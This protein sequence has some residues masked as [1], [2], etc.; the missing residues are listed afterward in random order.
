MPSRR[1]RGCV[2]A[3]AGVAAFVA[4]SCSALWWRLG[5]GPLSIDLVTPWLISALEERLGGGHRI[6]V[7]GTVLERDE[8]GRT[9]LRLRD[10]VLRGADGAVIASAPRAEVGIA[11]AS[12]LSGHLRAERLSLIGAEMALR[13]E[14]D[15]SLNVFAGS[16]DSSPASG[17]IEHVASVRG[18]DTRM[19]TAMAS[20]IKEA[21]ASAVGPGPLATAVGWLRTLDAVGF[22]GQDLIEIGLKNGNIAVDDRRTGKQLSFG[23]INLSLTRLNQGGAA[24]NLSSMGTDGPWSIN[25]TVVPR[26]DGS[27]SIEAVVR[28]VSPKDIQLA[29]RMDG[30]D[31]QADMPLSAVIRAEVGPDGV[32]QT[33]QGRMLAGAGYIGDV[34]D[35]TGRILIDEAQVELRWDAASRSMTVP[36]EIHAGA[37]RVTLTAQVESPRDGNGL[38]SFTIPQGMVQLASLGKPHEPPL[39]LDRVSLRAVFDADKKRFDLEQADLRG[40]SGGV[41]LSG[42]LDF[43]GPDPRIMVG[44][45]G[46][47]M[48]AAAF[49]RLWPVF[50]APH[51]RHWVEE[52]V[53]AG[54]VDRVVV[55]ANMRL[56]SLRPDGRAL[57]E[58]ALSIEIVSKGTTIRPVDGL[59]PVKDVELVTRV[60]GK[61]ASVTFGRGLVDLPSG[62]KL[63]VA[64]GSFE[65][66][67]INARQH[68][69]RA[70]FRIDGGLE[71]AAELLAM[72]P[73]R[74]AAALPFDVGTA[75]GAVAA[76]VAIALPLT[77]EM[78]KGSVVYGVDA[79]V[80]GFTAE[81]FVRGQKTEAA[82]LRVTANQDV[83][84]IKG[85]MKIGGTPGAVDYR[86]ARGENEGELRI[87]A[88]LDDAGRA[89]LGLD[90]GT[91][92]FGP[93][94]VKM[95]GR[96]KLAERDSRFNIEADLTQ[97]R[98][99][100][101]LPGWN[102]P[103][104]RAARASFV[105]L[106]RVQSMRLE[107]FVLDG[108]GAAVK[109]SLEIDAQGDIL[110]AN[111]P[112][113]AITDGDKASLKAER[114]SDGTLKVTLRGD[115]FDGR[116]LSKAAV[117]GQKPEQ[118]SR[119]PAQDLDL[120][121]KLG[122]VS[123]H[124]GETLRG[125]DLRLSR[126]AGHI[127]SFN[128]TGRL[129]SDG[130]VVGDLRARG[131]ARQVI[132]VE[133]TD[134]GALFRFTDT[135]PRIVGGAVSV[136][137][138]PPTLDN[139][140]QEGLLNIRDFTIRG[141]TVLERVASSG[142]ADDDRGATRSVAASGGVPFSRMRV[143][144]T[145]S[146]GRFVIREGV[147]WGP[148][149]GATIDGTL[150]YFRDEVRLRGT[151]VPA[152][153]L[154]NMFSRLPILGMFLGGGAN[155]G[156]LGVT[157]QVVGS[158]TAPV[159]QVNPMSAVAPGFLRKLFE[160]RG[161][162]D[163]TGWVAEPSR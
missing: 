50:V 73:V 163:R 96:M 124:H 142:P 56:A 44:L 67:D 128:L 18:L 61:T 118:R 7:S 95:S 21:S 63:T 30:G 131:N 32:P 116:G 136:A 88:T 135:Y 16:P 78:P 60:T 129:G 94:P 66:P 106:D 147:V 86:K 130:Q 119:R 127:R 146:P 28:D 49:K 74:E 139:A 93:V 62:R 27:R 104:G 13:I 31:F 141:E 2:L 24:L 8:D 46:T 20:P 143:E 52:H 12:L 72:E 5:N 91:A 17:A 102:K 65:V 36:I 161:G 85:D 123:G 37:S 76:Q 100:D 79:E 6:E 4:L 115:V 120:D 110:N 138:D 25:A 144:F 155:E 114:A 69:G 125:L 126:R 43:G 133:A 58:D 109:G 64:G 10:V 90:L 83:L 3:L 153:G 9:A 151:F 80:T 34:H 22:D 117:A 157:Y 99:T 101:L 89:R 107:D 51:L 48:G 148:S 55:A 145:R 84:H 87:Q 162:E 53:L 134:A 26:A 38:W 140:P 68:T 33:L 156:L 14:Q 39:M 47:R 137:M 122:T 82:I 41:A 105:L 54:T 29:L 112:N 159:L 40:A 57:P 11:G 160:F 45:A 103:A 150:D 158:P 77:K 152:Y 108:A 149:V 132:Y 23:Q 1:L 81:R 154:N 15:G 71:A 97:A 121:I 92:L 75:R 35:P 19:A 70:N 111:F 113:F 42:T 59:P 98:V